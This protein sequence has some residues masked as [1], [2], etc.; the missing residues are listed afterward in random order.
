MKF[1]KA[2]RVIMKTKE[3]DRATY[4]GKPYIVNKNGTV[5][6]LLLTSDFGLT[7][8]KWNKEKEFTESYHIGK[9]DIE[10]DWK[11][12]HYDTFRELV[13]NN[14][15]IHYMKYGKGVSERIIL[16]ENKVRLLPLTQN[17]AD[18]WKPVTCKKCLKLKGEK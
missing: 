16:C 13:K 17:Y 12:N 5:F 10:S 7:L 9:E 8:L 2:V 18:H 6:L 14:E 1:D 3:K 11:I 15:I 4:K